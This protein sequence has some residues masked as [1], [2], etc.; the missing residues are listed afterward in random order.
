M[1]APILLL[2]FVAGCNVLFPTAKSECV[3]ACDK[4]QSLEC[5][6]NKLVPTCVDTCL[7]SK[8][9]EIWDPQCVIKANSKEA[10]KTCR[11][12]CKP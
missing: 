3:E 12:R 5:L 6:E 10:L 4:M 9:Y 8:E 2:A 1:R 7:V 11:I